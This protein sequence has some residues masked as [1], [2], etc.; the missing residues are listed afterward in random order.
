MEQR[1][2]ELFGNV[3]TIFQ[4]HAEADASTAVKMGQIAEEIPGI[5]RDNTSS[6]AEIADMKLGVPQK[7]QQLLDKRR[8]FVQ[9]R[10]SS[11]EAANTEIQSAVRTMQ[12]Q[13][14]NLMAEAN[15]IG[16]R[17]GSPGTGGVMARPFLDPKTMILKTVDGAKEA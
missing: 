6:R 13:S 15:R 17:T 8:H 3:D 16:Q 9:Q 5:I 7:F 2:N 10:T 1:L 14:H 12:D 11:L 4:E